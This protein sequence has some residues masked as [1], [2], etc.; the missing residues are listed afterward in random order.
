MSEAAR[1]ALAKKRRNKTE[2]DNIH[3]ISILREHL[4]HA[5]EKIF[6]LE[7]Q[8]DECRSVQPSEIEE[9]NPIISDLISHE[10]TSTTNNDY[11]EETFNLAVQL[12]EI[13]PKAYSLLASKLP[14]PKASL[15]D[16]LFNETISNIPDLLKDVKNV[17]D[18]VD[19]W[20]SKHAIP[21]STSIDACLA[22]DALYFKPDA[23]ITVDNC[24]S[25]TAFPQELRKTLPVSP[26]KYFTENPNSLQ[27]FLELNWDSII[28][29][30]F[31]FQVQPY[32]VAYR[33]FIVHVKPSANGKANDE[34]VTLLHQIRNE[35]KNRRINV[36]SYAFDGDNAYRHLHVMYYESYI[37]SV[38]SKDDLNCKFTKNLR[39]VSDY[40]HLIK[41][42][43][44][45][46]LAALLHTGFSIDNEAILIED[47]KKILNDMSDV[48]WCNDLYTKMHDK[49]PLEL[50]KTEN[51]LK[52]IQHK[53]FVAA[54][55]WFPITLSNI[56]LNQKDIGFE[57]REF[58]LKCAFFYLVYYADC[59]EKS[60]DYLPQ[61]KYGDSLDVTFYS[62]DLLIEF[63]N[64]I[65]SH[66]QLMNIEDDY[67]S[68]RNSSIPLEHKFGFARG[69][70]HDVHTLTRFLQVISATQGV[71]CEETTKILKNF[72]AEA[73]KI[74]GRVDTHGTTFE[75]KNKDSFLYTVDEYNYED[76]PY[77]PQSVARAFLFH[78]GFNVI[79]EDEDVPTIA[80]EY[81]II[82]NWAEFF[83]GEF[84]DNE[85][86]K[87]KEKRV[88]SLNKF[89]YGTD[90]CM[91]AKQR[92][93][94]IPVKL[95]TV[96]H[97]QNKRNKR[98]EIFAEL[99]KSRNIT[100]KKCELLALIQEIK[101]N[102][103]SC[104][105]PPA[106]KYS[107]KYL[108]DWLIDNIHIYYTS[109]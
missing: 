68:S 99:C 104:P 26:F 28:K 51:L 96:H 83:I 29:A 65:H 6:A 81:E 67:D 3:T 8:I 66:I 14:F 17:N 27:N 103:K 30:G 75:K 101:E 64:T 12:R 62:N 36:K 59:R 63:T 16:K 15:I 20:K 89:R 76:L 37:R 47:I 90:R 58:L 71:S 86:T 92:I 93:I 1:A 48:V 97:Q 107:K 32:N 94:G 85:P 106:A 52:L 33:P 25:G 4:A 11:C 74:K 54:A 46:L 91:R 42:L 13:S 87:R 88:I 72:N 9:N 61:R 10:G 39:I 70:S 82:L 19:M 31:V 43:R 78:A 44:Y 79:R 102:C 41:R 21:A 57:Y 105:K 35:L 49:L 5:E 18:L 95:P 45:R 84:V 73:E 69:K 60:E 53:K 80:K 23:E 2:T 98:E 24:I 55:Y 40:L 7:S 22:V 109:F 50:F 34:V 56:A 38:L 77:S 108:Y 100:M